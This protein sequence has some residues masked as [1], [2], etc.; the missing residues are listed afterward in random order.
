MANNFIL[1]QAIELT[2]ISTQTAL[3]IDLDPISLALSNYLILKTI[4]THFLHE[5]GTKTSLTKKYFSLLRYRLVNKSWNSAILSVTF[6]PFWFPLR[7]LF[8]QKSGECCT[9]V[10]S[11]PLINPLLCRRLLISKLRCQLESKNQHAREQSIAAGRTNIF[12]FLKK[13]HQEVTSLDFELESKFEKTLVSIFLEYC[14]NVRSPQI[15]CLKCQVKTDFSQM[16]L[17]FRGNDGLK[18]LRICNRKKRGSAPLKKK[19]INKLL[20]KAPNLESLSIHC[21]HFPDLRC[22]SN[23]KELEVCNTLEK[24]SLG[25]AHDAFFACKSDFPLFELPAMPRLKIFKNYIPLVLPPLN[26]IVTPNLESLTITYPP[27]VEIPPT[28]F[29]DLDTVRYLKIVKL[30]FQNLVQLCCTFRYI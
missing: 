11:P 16:D 26:P 17:N 12:S 29:Q 22:N 5:S 24:L 21:V 30:P 13:Y 20:Y 25:T 9:V 18:H 8:Y 3:Q 27:Q 23:L 15:N 28:F 6:T 1:H 19:F 2:R 7:N 4:L 14:L 10:V